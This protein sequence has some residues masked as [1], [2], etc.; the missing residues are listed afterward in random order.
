MRFS[1]LFV[2]GLLIGAPPSAALAGE[3]LR[4]FD[5]DRQ[6]AGAAGLE[7]IGP[8]ER[9]D[10]ARIQVSGKGGAAL[11]KTVLVVDEPGIRSAFYAVRGQVRTEGV[12]GKGYLEMWSLFPG[13]G[14]YFSRTL[15]E[16]GPMGHLGGSQDWRP[17]VLPF[18]A[19]P[20][21]PLPVKLEIDVVLPGGGEV[22]IGQLQL[23][24]LEPGEN[25]L[26]ASGQWFGGSQAGFL[27]GLAG[28]FVGLLGVLIGW[29]GSRG[30]ARRFVLGAMGL[31]ALIGVAGL[32]VGLLALARSQPW[33]VYYPFGLAGLICLVL[34]VCL[35]R[36]VR[37]RYEQIE[38]RRMRA[39]DTP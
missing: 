5:W 19:R 33:V 16:G 20:G 12:A 13:G 23:V 36:P 8:D 11:H 27:G 30:R 6:Q 26:F 28:G 3:V 10:F 2:I 31:M 24:Q 7:W 15:G 39:L 34:P 9:V 21:G 25:P 35:Y 18:Q 4:T 22:W 37:R 32:A 17:F 29:L 1:V 38:L 14:K